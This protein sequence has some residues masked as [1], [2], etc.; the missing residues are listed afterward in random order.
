MKLCKNCK[1][2]RRDEY[3]Y[4]PNCESCVKVIK[5]KD[6]LIGFGI[7]TKKDRER[8]YGRFLE[9]YD[10]GYFREYEGRLYITKLGRSKMK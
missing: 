2:E 1:A 9:L 4:D 5:M 7:F 8:L 3:E 10:K 6:E